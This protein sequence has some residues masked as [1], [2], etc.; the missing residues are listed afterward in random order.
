[1][2]DEEGERKY[3][4]REYGYEA[5]ALTFRTEHPAPPEHYQY[6]TMVCARSGR[7]SYIYIFGGLNIQLPKIYR[8]R[9]AGAGEAPQ[10]QAV[11]FHESTPTKELQYHLQFRRFLGVALFGFNQQNHSVQLLIFGGLRKLQ[12]METWCIVEINQQEENPV[13]KLLTEV[14]GKEIKNSKHDEMMPEKGKGKIE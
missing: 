14:N 5:E 12:Q 10:W 11:P 8:L 6:S 9:V 4:F 13:I 7:S 3:R 1:M 2:T